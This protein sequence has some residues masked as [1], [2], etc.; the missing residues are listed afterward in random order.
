MTKRKDERRELLKEDEL[1]SRM[2]RAARYTQDN[3]GI[4]FGGLALLLLV[5]GGISAAGAMSQSS[6]NEQAATIYKTEKILE[7]DLSAEDAEYSTEL[8]RAEAA[9]TELDGSLGELSGVARHQA[10]ALKANLLITLGRQDETEAIYSELAD[11]GKGAL[12]LI[13]ISGMGDF[14]LGEQKYDEAANWYDQLSQAGGEDFVALVTYKKAVIK[15]KQ[16]DEAGAA[17]D[18]SALIDQYEGTDDAKPP[19]LTQAQQLL[20]ELTEGEEDQES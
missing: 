17:S 9:L 12:K 5:V 15:Q 1:L 7:S 10:L 19:V 6:A 11:K 20:T 16:G 3:P 18:L 2:D 8:Q 13:G 4:V 14:L